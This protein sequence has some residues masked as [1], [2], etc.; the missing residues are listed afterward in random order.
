MQLDFA[1]AHLEL[2][3][4][5]PHSG[6]R[7]SKDAVLGL[8]FARQ[9][10]VHAIASDRRED[11]DAWPGDLAYAAPGV[12]IFSES[13]HG[14]EY[15]AL[16]VAH[17]GPMPAAPRQ[18]FYGDR[19]AVAIGARLRRALLAAQPD[20][21][22]IEQHAALLL[23][24]GQ[25]LLAQPATP[26][27]NYAKERIK[28]ARVLDHIE[29]AIEQG[30]NSLLGLD[31]L[32]QCAGMP[33]LHFLRSFTTAIGATPHAYITER[34]VQRARLLLRASR[35]PLADIAFD[36]GF[37]HQSHLGA[38]FKSRLGISPGAYRRLL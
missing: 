16:Q 14:G 26:A 2:F 25:A 38:A 3:A 17:T 30:D 15:L 21:L 13:A 8:A 34:R 27:G 24:R 7:A 37:A 11:F 20:V 33:V 23:E 22:Q 32:A 36:C 18:V 10:G 5:T 6:G 4:A 28:H 31:A 1:W 35:A 12:E 9:R 29:H 19:H